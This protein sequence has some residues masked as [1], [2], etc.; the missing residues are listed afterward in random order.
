MADLLNYRD[1]PDAELIL[2]YKEKQDKSCITVLYTRYSHLVFGVCLKYLK[3]EDES[4]DAV[5]QIFE[6]LMT[7]LLK[8]EIEFFRAWLHR[9]AKNHCL[10]KFRGQKRFVQ[11]KDYHFV[12]K[13]ENMHPS[14]GFENPHQHEE[15]LQKMESAITRLE[16][17]QKTCIE[18]FYLQEMSYHQVAEKTGYTLM[19]VKSYIQNG[20]RNLKIMLEKNG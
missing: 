16:E 1:K 8:Y 11:G 17:K 4:K 20:K 10:L 3:D 6:K 12:E 5:M 19:Q 7:D 2:I 9:V 15:D 14:A 18:L 13:D